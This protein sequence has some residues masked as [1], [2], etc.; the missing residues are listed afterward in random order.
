MDDGSSG[1]R[2]RIFTRRVKKKVG[3]AFSPSFGVH[4]GLIPDPNWPP[5]EFP[6]DSVAM[7]RKHRRI[8]C[9]VVV[10]VD[11]RRTAVPGD[12]S[13][14][15]AMFLLPLRAAS[16]LVTIEVRGVRAEAKILSVSKKGAQVA[17]HAQFV[18]AASAKAL[19][20]KL[21]HA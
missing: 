18:D 8:A 2:V 20:A 12:L 10:E 6:K 1:P 17:H 14:G 7:Q 19:W 21:L 5:A 4:N 9:E 11:G 16:D 13:A 3:D 15:G